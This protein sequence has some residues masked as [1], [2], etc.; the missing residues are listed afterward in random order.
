[1][2][3]LRFTRMVF[4][5]DYNKLKI[6]KDI[7]DPILLTA[8]MI[9][10]D[11]VNKIGTNTYSFSLF[12]RNAVKTLHEELRGASKVRLARSNLLSSRKNCRETVA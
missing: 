1:M 8:S 7:I 4:Y 2:E 9:I 3:G 6:K 5:G 12:S 11:A 10:I